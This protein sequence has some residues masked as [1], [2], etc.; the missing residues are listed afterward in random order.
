MQCSLWIWQS[1]LKGNETL[2]QRRSLKGHFC[3]LL[4]WWSRFVAAFI[5]ISTVPYLA[6]VCSPCYQHVRVCSGLCHQ[7]VFMASSFL[8]ICFV[9]TFIFFLRKIKGVDQTIYSYNTFRFLLSVLLNKKEMKG[10]K[11]WESKLGVNVY[12]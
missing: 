12:C 6:F 7:A 9:L 11:F 2:C 1:G 10:M 4:C 5:G 8:F 3:S